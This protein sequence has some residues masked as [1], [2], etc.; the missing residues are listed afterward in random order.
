MLLV[1]TLA[2]ADT[3]VLVRDGTILRAGQQQVKLVDR[4]GAV[5]MRLISEDDGQL[6]VSPLHDTAGHCYTG[7]ISPDLDVQ[8]RISKD[9][10]WPV[11]AAEFMTKDGAVTVHAGARVEMADKGNW[12]A[13]VDGV[14]LTLP[15]PL[16]SVAYRYET[17]TTWPGGSTTLATVDV[18][19]FGTLAVRP[20]GGATLSEGEGPRTLTSRCLRLSGTVSGSG[21]GGTAEGLGGM[22]MKSPARFN[23]PEGTPLTW[24]D[25]SP[26]G[27]VLTPSIVTLADPANPKLCI[28]TSLSQSKLRACFDKKLAS[29]IPVRPG[30]R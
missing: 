19:G 27:A 17:M 14:A 11:L 28:D 8:L 10:V 5:A 1:S 12:T 22:G 24:P 6:V 2:L 25:G 21:G 26:A 18:A 7:A 15:I 29:P 9:D 23:V 4:A 3:F 30:L 20:A 13:T 16:A